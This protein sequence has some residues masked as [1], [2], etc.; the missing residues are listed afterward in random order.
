MTDD[1]LFEYE[2]V[3]SVCKL[4]AVLDAGRGGYVH[5]NPADA[6]LCSILRGMWPDRE[7]ARDD[8]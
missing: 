1:A 6:A 5:A 2:P 8:A 7:A 3:C 4:P